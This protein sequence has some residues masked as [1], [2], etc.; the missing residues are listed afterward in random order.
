MGKKLLPKIEEGSQ[1]VI[2]SSTALRAQQ[3]AQ[4][5]FHA[6]CYNFNCTLDLTY[7]GLC[8]LGQGR[9]EGLP[10]DQEY[11]EELK[12]WEERSAFDKVML[13]KVFTG[14]SYHGVGERCKR[15][16]QTIYNKH[17]G[18]IIF[19]VSHNAA[20]NAMRININQVELPHDHPDLPLISYHNC[21]LIKLDVPSSGNIEE[22]CFKTNI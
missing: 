6:L 21:D 9:W 3:T 19:V 14:E 8:E 16:L 4:E 13:P 1:I 20:M 2:C 18:K 15:D 12:K 17:A 7:D 10:K 22:A 5:I 11:K